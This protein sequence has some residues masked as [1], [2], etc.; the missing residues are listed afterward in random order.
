[1]Y[2]IFSSSDRWRYE[3]KRMVKVNNAFYTR[4]GSPPPA[5]SFFVAEYITACTAVVGRLAMFRQCTD[6][7]H[8]AGIYPHPQTLPTWVE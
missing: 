4:L 6:L 7:M 1:M 5:I 3:E 8:R 2:R